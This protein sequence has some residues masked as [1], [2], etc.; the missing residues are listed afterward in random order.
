MSPEEAVA[1]RDTAIAHAAA[2]QAQAVAGQGYAQTSGGFAAA[3]N[4]ADVEAAT[5]QGFTADALSSSAQAAAS[6]AAQAQ[7]NMDSGNYGAVAAASSKRWRPSAPPWPRPM[8][9]APASRA[10]V[11]DS[12]PGPAEANPSDHT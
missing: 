11:W 4:A 3:Q 1:A 12:P 9:A 10:L 5:V 8:W 2:A 6:H 7:S